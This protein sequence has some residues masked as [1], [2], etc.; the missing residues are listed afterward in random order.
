MFL[1]NYWLPAFF[2]GIG[3]STYN[4][5]FGLRYDLLYTDRKSIYSNAL[6][7]FV[8]VYF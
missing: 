1:E 6:I 4:V 8:R 3:Y 7:P 2:V 5:T